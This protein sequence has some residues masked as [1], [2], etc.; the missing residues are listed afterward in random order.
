M[1]LGIAAAPAPAGQRDDHN[2]SKL[3][4]R[5]LSVNRTAQT[6][7]LQRLRARHGDDRRQRLTKFDDIRFSQVRPGKLLEVR[8]RV[9]NGRKVATKIQQGGG[10]NS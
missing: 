3:E 6:F 9:I 10:H 2:T 4:G 7:R 5:V 1:A 8:Y